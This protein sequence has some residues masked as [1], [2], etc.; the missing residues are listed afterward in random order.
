MTLGHDSLSYRSDS[1]NLHKKEENNLWCKEKSL[2][3]PGWL[4]YNT[5]GV[6]EETL[7]R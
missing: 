6:K 4:C 2:D 5:A 7:I 1:L 3:I